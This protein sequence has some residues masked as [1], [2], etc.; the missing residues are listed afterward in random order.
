MAKFTDPRYLAKSTMRV[1]PCDG[2]QSHELE[3]T[4]DGRRRRRDITTFCGNDHYV[5]D[6][7]MQYDHNGRDGDVAV[8][9]DS[10]GVILDPSMT[11]V[12][13]YGKIEIGEV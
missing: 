9:Y 6:V 7:T 1:V 2:H 10:G 11:A 8:A 13:T 12:V 4:K 3:V 5:V